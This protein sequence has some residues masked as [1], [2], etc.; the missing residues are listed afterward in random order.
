VSANPIRWKE[1]QNIYRTNWNISSIPTLV[2]YERVDGEPAETG[3]LVEGEILSME[4]LRD[5]VS[6]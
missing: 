1:P 2:Q 3:R 5:F 4:K 6:R